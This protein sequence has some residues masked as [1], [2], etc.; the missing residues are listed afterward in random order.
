MAG[1]IV[2]QLSQT[3]KRLRSFSGPHQSPDR[4]D[5]RRKNP[6]R[7]G[8]MIAHAH[9]CKLSVPLRAAIIR[10]TQSTSRP[11]RPSASRNLGD[12]AILQGR[13]Q[14]NCSSRRAI[15]IEAD[16]FG[17]DDEASISKLQGPQYGTIC[18]RS[19]RRFTKRPTPDCPM[20]FSLSPF[21]AA[22]ARPA[23]FPTCKITQ[24][25]PTRNTGHPS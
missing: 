4:A 18:W 23:A 12:R 14:K 16:L 5:G 6:L 25:R 2:F 15:A 1:D 7:R 17:I 10:D 20:K 19:R 24:N 9:R 21:H 8:R 13:L 11:A 3:Q 22:G